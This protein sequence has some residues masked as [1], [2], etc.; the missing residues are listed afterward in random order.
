MAFG[1]FGN[2]GDAIK[3]FGAWN[4]FKSNHPKFP[5]FLQAVSRRGFKEDMVIEIIVTEP[6][7]E[8][9]ETSI[10]VQPGD[11]ELLNNL[12]AEAAKQDK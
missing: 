1:N 3:L 8:R 10:K 4:K 7:G 2:M 6:D 9:I 12:K 5:A 11:V